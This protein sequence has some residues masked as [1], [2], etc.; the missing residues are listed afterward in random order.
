MEDELRMTTMTGDLA[1]LV[2][3][4]REELSRFISTYVDDSIGTGKNLFI[5]KVS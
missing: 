4:V 1:W 3:A 5:K 2:K